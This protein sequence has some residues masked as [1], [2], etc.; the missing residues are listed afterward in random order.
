MTET[1][2]S[3]LDNGKYGC[4]V[5]IDLR[6]AF[7][8]VNHSMLLKKM[9]HY[10]IKK[11]GSLSSRGISLDW[12]SSDLSERKQYVSVNSH[13]SDYLDIPCGV[14]QGS[15]LGLLF[16][17]DLPNVSKFLS[18]YLFADDTNIYFEATDLVSLQKIMNQE[19]KYVKNGFM[20]IN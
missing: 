16:L 12:F 17:S 19:L 2:Q 4:G 10:V 15:V 20:L 11:D 6:K 5:F 13:I 9:G 3:T 1:I 7:D 18:F 14:P 8:T